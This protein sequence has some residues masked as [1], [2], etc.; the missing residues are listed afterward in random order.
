MSV[1]ESV[2]GPPAGRAIPDDDLVSLFVF[3]IGSHEQNGVKLLRPV[4]ES[5]F[6]AL[7]DGTFLF[8]L[9]GSF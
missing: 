9:H 7:S 8:S 4:S 1:L 3:M 6:I 2:L 5:F